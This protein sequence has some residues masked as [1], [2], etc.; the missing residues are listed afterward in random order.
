MNT[1]LIVLFVLLALGALVMVLFILSLCL[2]A[3]PPP[4]HSP[5]GRFL[6]LNHPDWRDH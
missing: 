3:K 5:M 1:A 6:A 2:A 4:P